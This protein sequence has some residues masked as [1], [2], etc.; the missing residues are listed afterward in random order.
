[1][2]PLW[3]RVDLGVIAIKGNSIISKAPGL[4]PHNQIQFSVIS[5]HSFGGLTPSEKGQS[6]YST[7]ST[8]RAVFV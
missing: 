6:P 4:E 7:A 1:M 8:N 3:V 2:L 5:G